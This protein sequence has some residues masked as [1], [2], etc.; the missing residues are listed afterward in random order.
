MDASS[1]QSLYKNDHLSSFAKKMKIMRENLPSYLSTDLPLK[2][3]EEGLC[4]QGG[5]RLQ[6]E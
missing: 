6:L 3:A 4:L 1:S 2:G 5:E